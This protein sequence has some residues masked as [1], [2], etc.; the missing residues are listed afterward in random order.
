MIKRYC[1]ICDEE[2][3]ERNSV[4][5]AQEDFRLKAELKSKDGIELQV[6]VVTAGNGIWNKGDF[7]KYCVLDALY[8][9]DDRPKVE[10]ER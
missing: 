1:D 5:F 3:I 4:S 8:Q 9:L 10:Y 6:E 2:I 7:C